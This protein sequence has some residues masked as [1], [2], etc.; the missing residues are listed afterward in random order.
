[1]DYLLEKRLVKLIITACLLFF[2]ILLIFELFEVNK[3]KEYEYKIEFFEYYLSSYYD[4]NPTIISDFIEVFDM[5]NKNRPDISKK[6]SPIEMLAIGKKET[7]FKNVK[8]DGDDSLGF[9]KVQEPTYWFV[10]NMYEE[11]FYEIDFLGLPWVW[12]NVKSRPD[13]QILSSI[14]YLYYLKDRFSEEYAFY[15]YNGGNAYYQQD[16]M[17]I[18][19]NLEEEY[20]QYKKQK[21]RNYID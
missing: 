2:I 15:H 5:L 3:R 12:D 16:V 20:R 14:L 13:A 17:D 8:G 21:E 10:K 11:L 9:F 18:I 6:I 1:V 19:K 7:N 4:L